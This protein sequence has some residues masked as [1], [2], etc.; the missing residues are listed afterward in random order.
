MDMNALNFCRFSL[1]SRYE[2][3][4]TSSSSASVTKALIAIPNLVESSL[5]SNEY[6]LL[7]VHLTE[8]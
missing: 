4:G 1:L 6:C 8:G 5:V 7:N 2:A 3:E